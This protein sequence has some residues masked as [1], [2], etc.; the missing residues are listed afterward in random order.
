MRGPLRFGSGWVYN[1]LV[2]T[3]APP[4]IQV[5]IPAMGTLDCGQLIVGARGG[6]ALAGGQDDGDHTPAGFVLAYPAEI[7]L[8]GNHV[9][10]SL[11]LDV[12]Q[13]G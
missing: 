3:A 2:L 6:L 10:R 11:D 12:S 13:A 4:A 9:L 1:V 5:F 8:T 7:E